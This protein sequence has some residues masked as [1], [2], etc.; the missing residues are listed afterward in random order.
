MDGGGLLRRVG[1]AFI[2]LEIDEIEEKY[3]AVSDLVHRFLE[4][5]FDRAPCEAI[6]CEAVRYRAVKEKDL[7]GRN[8]QFHRVRASDDR[9][10]PFGV[11]DNLG[12]FV[13]CRKLLIDNETRRLREY[14]MPAAGE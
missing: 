1:T 12:D 4:K 2:V 3:F 9:R 11:A 6:V 10:Q 8:L 13:P 5:V 14:G 7:I